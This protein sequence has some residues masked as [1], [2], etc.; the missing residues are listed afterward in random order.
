MRAI[1]PPLDGGRVLLAGCGRG[2]HVDYFLDAGAT[3]VGVDASEAAVETARDRWDGEDDAE[4][5][6]ADLTDP[7]TFGDGRFDLVVSNLVLSHVE[8]WRPVFE[9]FRRV[10]SDR[11]T[12]AFSTIHPLYH[13]RQWDLDGYHRIQR[14]VVEWPGA[15]LPTYYRPMSAVVQSLVDTGFGIERFEEPTPQESYRDANPE[16]YADAMASPEVLVVRAS[17]D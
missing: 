1:L 4:F 15:E 11:G 14:R 7:L 6:R 12:L 10:L 8:A 16:R 17:P 5:E 2:D 13:R 9:E 3:V